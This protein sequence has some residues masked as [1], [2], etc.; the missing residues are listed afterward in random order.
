L[1]ILRH[2]GFAKRISTSTQRLVSTAEQNTH[3][4]Q[5][6]IMVQGWQRRAEI[7]VARR[8]ESKQRKQKKNDRANVKGMVSNLMSQMDKVYRRV[9]TTATTGTSGRNAASDSASTIGTLHVWTEDLPSSWS[10][11][12]GGTGMASHGCDVEDSM[13]MMG[14]NRTT[15]TA[16]TVSTARAT[17][18]K[19]Q[20]ASRKKDALKSDDHDEAFSGT[21]AGGAKR[22]LCR[23]QF[24]KGKCDKVKSG[25]KA[26]TASCGACRHVHYANNKNHQ[27]KTLGDILIMD[28]CGCTALETAE[29]AFLEAMQD[30]GTTK[31]RDEELGGME[32]IY[33]FSIPLSS[34]AGL[35]DKSVEEQQSVGQILS[36]ALHDQ[37]CTH[38]SLVYVAYENELI[39]D[40]YQ[41]GT[42]LP[43][44]GTVFGDSKR[45]TAATTPR[46]AAASVL[47]QETLES[48]LVSAESTPGAILEY[49]LMFLPDTAISSMARVCKAWNNEIGRDSSHLWCQMLDRRI[50]PRPVPVVPGST[51]TSDRTSSH[52]AKYCFQMHYRIVRDVNAVKDALSALFNPRRVASD[53][54]EMVYQAFSTRRTAPSEPNA[55][56]AM[57]VWSPVEVIAAYSN[58]C[59]LR[60]F[61]AA[62]RGPAQ[63]GRACRE[64]IS[65]CVNPYRK[66]TRRKAK[67]V[68]MGL[69]D[70]TIGSLLQVQGGTTTK[71]ERFL[72][73]MISRDDFLEAAGGDSSSLGWSELDDGILQVIDIG[74]AM[75][76]YILTAD[77]MD[78]RLADFL[79]S[80]GEMTDIEV[81]VSKSLVACGQTRFAV[82][83]RI[84]IPDWD[85][86]DNIHDEEEP[87]MMLGRKLVIFSASAGGIAWMGNSISSPSTTIPREHDVVLTGA[88]HDAT[89]RSG[90]SIVA[91]SAFASSATIAVS[92]IDINGDGQGSVIPIDDVNI[93][94]Q[95]RS[96]ILSHKLEVRWEFSPCA[97]LPVAMFEHDIVAVDVL[98]RDRGDDD[99]DYL[100]VV[101]FYPRGSICA[102]EDMNCPTNWLTF[103]L[104]HVLSMERIREE[105]V[106]LICNQVDWWDFDDP[107]LFRSL[108]PDIL[109]F[110]NIIHV[111]TRQLIHRVQLPD[112]TTRTELSFYDPPQSLVVCCGGNTIGVGVWWKG[113]V[114]TGTDV[115]SVGDQE[116]K[117]MLQQQAAN[118]A[119]KKKKL[120]R[121]IYSRKKEGRRAPRCSS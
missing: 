75:V 15:A 66:T 19:P 43:D 30:A 95:D 115:R 110:A 22:Y 62:E 63:G 92:N 68:A 108:R 88:R 106:L 89:S 23:T 31:S 86:E 5:G 49:I 14:N 11:I 6:V 29:T 81:I 40:R 61:K 9:A 46:S 59:T 32:M 8:V 64:L 112:A 58:D 39:F 82:E 69:D 113:V 87:M 7:A 57:E 26:T 83:A 27:H 120:A 96:E 21:S 90:C 76:N 3:C 100:S 12:G 2:Q 99:R 13:G 16:T 51:N 47:H 45:T 77:D 10:S 34:I 71:D 56:V 117:D 104:C 79:G 114:M 38:A 1:N 20:P 42:L 72:L 85:A 33:Y 53:D 44:L 4:R 17:G 121:Q 98:F 105:H 119:R 94:N 97:R 50:W 84:S 55:C 24:Y 80:G 28:H 70:A 116:S 107:H 60:L 74:E 25:K 78:Y 37:S 54:V 65:V 91:V 36:K 93:A 102:T 118:E 41:E 111:P 109:S 18:K 35:E 52:D 48:T 101:S 67:L 103:E 73:S